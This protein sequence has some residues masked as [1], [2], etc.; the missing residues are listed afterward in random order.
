M[1]ARCQAFLLIPSAELPSDCTGVVLTSD[2]TRFLPH[3]VACL[4][5]PDGT[6]DALLVERGIISRLELGFF[7]V[8]AQALHC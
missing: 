6:W 4:G 1:V 5:P 3:V 8:V 7:G 2:T